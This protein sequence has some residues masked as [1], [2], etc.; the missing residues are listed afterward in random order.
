MCSGWKKVVAF[1]QQQSKQR[2]WVCS[3]PLSGM[4]WCSRMS[5]AFTV[6]LDLAPLAL[7]VEAGSVGLEIMEEIMKQRNSPAF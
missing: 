7:F 5:L 3:V 4:C 1:G 2:N 6:Q